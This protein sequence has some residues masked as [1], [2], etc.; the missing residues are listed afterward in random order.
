MFQAS[1]D[2][3]STVMNGHDAAAASK[4]G[5]VPGVYHHSEKDLCTP[6]Q[7]SQLSTSWAR[8]P[9]SVHKPRYLS[10][11]GTQNARVSRSIVWP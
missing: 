8:G 10:E 4:D 3:T 1:S 7:L 9:G 2:M 6:E 11:P 5:Q